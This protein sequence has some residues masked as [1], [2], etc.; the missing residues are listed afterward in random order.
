[1]L[2]A[3]SFVQDDDVCP[4]KNGTDRNADYWDEDDEYADYVAK[5]ARVA[6][7]GPTAEE[8]TGGSA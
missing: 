1:L 3:L 5:K 6:E 7:H 8:S 4:D 2:F